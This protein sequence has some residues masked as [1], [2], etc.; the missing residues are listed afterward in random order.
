MQYADIVVPRGE[1][2]H[3]LIC[4]A[5]ILQCGAHSH[6]LYCCCSIG[7]EN[8][9]AMNLIVQHVRDMLAK[10]CNYGVLS[11][12]YMSLLFVIVERSQCQV[13]HLLLGVW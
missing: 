10:V 4:M 6:L 7:A 9:V 1:L 3:K 2:R 13:G 11:G 12:C 5:L 8:H